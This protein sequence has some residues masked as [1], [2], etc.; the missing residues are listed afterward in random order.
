[1]NLQDG[2]QKAKLKLK[3]ILTPPL[4]AT[5][6]AALIFVLKPTVPAI[7]DDTIDTIGAATVP[8]SMMCIGLSLGDVPI[9]DSFVKPR[10]YL[11]SLVRLIICPLLVW[12][13]LG[14]FDPDPM[15]LGIAVV[16]AAC[17]S[18]VICAILGIQY[19][20]DGTEAS[21]A[22]FLS[23]ILSVITMPLLVYILG[24]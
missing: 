8:L 4:I 24:I 17:P 21:E 13:V 12:L 10:L 20:R 3:N 1:M 18:A 19:G 9:R 15:I 5:L 22:I 7:I 23:T 14:L 6:I 2:E 11:I 16:L